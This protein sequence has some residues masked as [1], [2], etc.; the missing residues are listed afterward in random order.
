[1][2][3]LIIISKSVLNWGISI[4]TDWG[5]F[6]SVVAVTRHAL[7]ILVGCAVLVFVFAVLTESYVSD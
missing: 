2:R 7:L 5:R 6:F 4:F 1:M 3:V